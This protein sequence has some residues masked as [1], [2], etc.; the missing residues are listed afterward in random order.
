VVFQ[1]MHRYIPA[2][3]IYRMP[4]SAIMWTDQNTP[5]SD[6]SFLVAA[7]RFEYTAFIAATLYQNN[8]VTQRRISHN[9][10]AERVPGRTEGDLTDVK[11]ANAQRAISENICCV[12]AGYLTYVR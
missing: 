12:N 8:E 3:Y 9:P 10:F 5:A 1:P 4:T 7:K 11:S 2:K 6:S